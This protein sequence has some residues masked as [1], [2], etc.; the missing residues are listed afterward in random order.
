MRILIREALKLLAIIATI[1]KVIIEASYAAHRL[2]K[3]ICHG[4]KKQAH[5]WN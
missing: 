4:K 2:S 1:A 3:T 5:T